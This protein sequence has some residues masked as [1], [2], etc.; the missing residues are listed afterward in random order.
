MLWQALTNTMRV[1]LAHV[2]R[3]RAAWELVMPAQKVSPNAAGWA[4]AYSPL[5]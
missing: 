1:L 4:R 3:R 2:I 5:T